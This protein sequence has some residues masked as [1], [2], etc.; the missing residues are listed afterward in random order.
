MIRKSIFSALLFGFSWNALAASP[1]LNARQARQE[2]RIE[3]GYASGDLT[4]REAARLESRQ[5]HI[6]R[7]EY[8][9]KADGH[10][11]ARERARLQRE[12]NR[13]S[14]AIHRQRHDAQSR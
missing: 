8:R 6:A 5:A 12:Q 4:A 1:V 7:V 13:A 2:T 3:H 10:L 11:G 14:L 9:A